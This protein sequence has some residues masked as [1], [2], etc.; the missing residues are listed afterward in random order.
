[1]SLYQ[2]GATW[3][4]YITH[5]GTRIRRSTGTTD[6][7]EA[8]RIHDQIKADLW[9]R[10][11]SGHRLTDAAAAW[12]KAAQR[13]EPERYMLRAFLDVYPDRPLSEITGLDI[14]HAIGD[15]SPATYTR[16]RNLIL[17]ILRT[18]AAA[19]W[20]SAAPR[21]ASRRQPPGRIRWI[22]RE[23]WARL[24]AELPQHL[25]PL[26]R[27][28]I[29]TGLRQANVLRLRWH[30]IDLGRRVMWVHADQAKARKPIGIPL[31][32]EAIDVLR[33]QVGAHADWVFPYTNK[34]EMVGGKPRVGPMR[35]IGNAFARAC[36]RSGL[37][38]FTWHDLR[39][40][41][42]TWHV[43]AGTP[44]EVL[45]KLGGWSDIRMVL[46]YAHFAPEYLSGWADNAKP[47]SGRKDVA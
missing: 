43:M 20:I 12:L 47:W 3:W 15:K 16:Y 7:R 40:T 33:G 24:D 28:A 45:Q 22:T 1:M 38:D 5:D 35:E 37:H 41:W 2:R 18:A 9:Q 39:H 46:R 19:G 10:R 13:S 32:A 27:F 14:E 26:A 42:A 29:A 8:Q 25:R 17:A 34:R 23:E 36:R 44:I 6:R 30:E 31:S 11:Q 21:I 4:V